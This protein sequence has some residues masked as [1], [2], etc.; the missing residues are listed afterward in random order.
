MQDFSDVGPC[1]MTVTDISHKFRLLYTEDGGT[2][3][4]A[5]S[6]LTS[7]LTWCYTADDFQHSLYIFTLKIKTSSPPYRYRTWCWM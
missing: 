4:S 1:Q 6:E 3:F 5:T 7:P 2:V